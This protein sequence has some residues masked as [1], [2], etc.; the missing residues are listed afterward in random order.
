MTVTVILLIKIIKAEELNAEIGG[1]FNSAY[2]LHRGEG[3]SSVA[4]NYS[5]RPETSGRH[6]RAS[7]HSV[8]PPTQL[9]ERSRAHTEPE[10]STDTFRYIYDYTPEEQ[11]E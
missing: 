10:R 6:S 7:S 11:T 1:A 5:E 4:S 2:T 3:A 9:K 8:S